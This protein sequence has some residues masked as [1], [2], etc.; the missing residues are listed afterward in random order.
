MSESSLMMDALTL[1][2]LYEFQLEGDLQPPVASH[3][4]P[5]RSTRLHLRVWGARPRA[6]PR[7]HLPVA[8]VPPSG[9]TRPSPG[10]RR[11][12]R[13]RRR[14]PLAR[15]AGPRPRYGGRGPPRYDS[16][17]Y[18]VRDALS[19]QRDR[20]VSRHPADPEAV[21]AQAWIE[22]MEQLPWRRVEKGF[23]APAHLREALDR[24]HVGRAREKNQALDYLVARHAAAERGAA[25]EVPLS[26]R[27]RLYRQNQ[28]GPGAA[29]AL[30][31][32]FAR[33]SLTGVEKPA[34]I[35]G[36]ARPAPAAAPGRLV[37]ALRQLGPL[38][39]HASDNP[40]VVLGELDRLGEAAA[41]ALLGAIDPERNH[42]FRD[43]YVGLPLDLSAVL[44]VAVASDP[45]H[46]PPR[47]QERLEALPL[48]GYTDTEKQH[49]A[50]RHLIP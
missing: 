30:G 25:G 18:H 2:K 6:A 4:D 7:Q 3:V 20:V 22:V 17:P 41:D 33:V 15:L 14:G 48:A 43:R 45:A 12:R 5:G 44:F 38:S 16:L 39:G 32:R 50:T 37:D 13:R 46:I 34:G 29:A 42:S 31:R 1:K 9:D 36:V 28:L 27:S 21:A 24:E 40:L 23:D 49:I 8:G 10:H 26:L 35:L 47:L 19:R 11:R